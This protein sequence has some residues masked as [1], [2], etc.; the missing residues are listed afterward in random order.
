MALW[1]WSPNRF[2]YIFQWRY[3]VSNRQCY[4][5]QWHLNLPTVTMIFSNGTV[6][7]LLTGPVISSTRHYDKFPMTLLS[8]DR[9][10]DIFQRQRGFLTGPA[11]SFNGTIISKRQCYIFQWRL[12]L[13]C[14]TMIIFNFPSVSL[15][16]M[17]MVYLPGNAC[18]IQTFK[19]LS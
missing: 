13:P 17:A 5:L 11:I 16:A 4:I 19:Y 15:H 10:C 6:H 18:P 2:C 8:L 14:V 12:N 9:S 3:I 7:S 1:L